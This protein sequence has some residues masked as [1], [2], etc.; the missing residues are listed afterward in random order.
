MLTALYL[1]SPSENNEENRTIKNLLR[2]TMELE[3]NIK[4]LSNNFTVLK[5]CFSSVRESLSYTLTQTLLCK[6]SHGIF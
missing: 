4:E 2:N 5:K 6:Y 3:L 1:P